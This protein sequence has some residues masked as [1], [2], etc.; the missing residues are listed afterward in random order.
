MKHR[1]KDRNF[2]FQIS[3]IFSFLNTVP[4][5]LS[6]P[7]CTGCCIFNGFTGCRENGKR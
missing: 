5:M 2:L 3:I 6:W 4:P 7:P 1:S